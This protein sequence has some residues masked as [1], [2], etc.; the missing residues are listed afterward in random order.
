[1]RAF[2]TFL[3]VGASTALLVAACE[4]ERSAPSSDVVVRRLVALEAARPPRPRPACL[5]ETDW[6]PDAGAPNPP[7]LQAEAVIVRLR[8]RFRHCYN[9][10]LATHPGEEGCANI[11]VHVSPD[12]S[13]TSAETTSVDGLSPEVTLCLASMLRESYFGAPGGDGATIQVPVKFMF[14]GPFPRSPPPPGP[15]PSSAPH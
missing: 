6:A 5:S 8:P 12:G 1:M 15:A 14:G 7:A 11:A 4:P 3:F 13:V 2:L 10:R 9:E